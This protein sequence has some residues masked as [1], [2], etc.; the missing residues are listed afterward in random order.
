M[1]YAPY[2]FSKITT[3][4]ECQ[5]KFDFTYVNKIAIDKEYIDPSYFIRGRFL[6]AYI[7]DRLKGGEGIDIGVY[8]IDEQEKMNLVDIAENTL[9]HEY[10]SF[11]F[12]FDLNMIEKQIFLGSKLE[13]V[14]V[15]NEAAF[16]GY[17]DYI[18]AKDD[19]GIII[20][21]KTGKHK[22]DPNFA[23][24]EL[25]AIWLFQKKPQ[26]TEID[27]IFFYVEHDALVN[28][29]VTRKNV[30]EMKEDLTSVIEIIE[31]TEEFEISES[32]NCVRCQFYQNCIKE[33]G[34]KIT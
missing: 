28:K 10:V 29:T 9:T 3:F 20:D 2:S 5:K 31:H 16:V 32:K 24:L 22:E 12:D 33:F 1:K 25:Y 15:K 27:L 13:P 6:H 26:L 23:Q 14:S 4:L 30:E 19:L 21:W 11:T 34:I 7:A 8:N 18:A 17:I